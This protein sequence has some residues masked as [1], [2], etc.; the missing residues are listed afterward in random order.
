MGVESRAVRKVNGADNPPRAQGRRHLSSQK[1]AELSHGCDLGL[2]KG[3]LVGG[4]ATDTLG[5][6]LSVAVWKKTKKK[7]EFIFFI[8]YFFIC[9]FIFLFISFILQMKGSCHEERVRER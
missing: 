6:P 7:D 1:G 3:D 9:S 5:R 2:F 8:N 4:V